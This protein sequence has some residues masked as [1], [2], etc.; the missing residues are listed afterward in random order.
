M[1]KAAAMNWGEPQRHKGH[2]ELPL[3]NEVQRASQEQFARQSSNY[4]KGHI[5]Q[6]VADVQAALTHIS[7][8]PRARV[9]DVAT[10]GGHTGLLLAELGH[11]VT[12]SDITPAMLER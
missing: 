8:P 7:L 10:G 4:G 6:N 12:V 11:E 1:R 9:L 3:L 5:L 2:E